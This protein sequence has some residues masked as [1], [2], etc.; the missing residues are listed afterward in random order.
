MP[1]YNFLCLTC[2]KEF[3]K[4]LTISEYEKGGIVCPHCKSKDVEQRWA[5]LCSDLEEELEGIFHKGL[6]E[7]LPSGARSLLI[8][9]MI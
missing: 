1:Q 5:A 6:D 8:P 2:K 4:I 7:R 3:S 9:L